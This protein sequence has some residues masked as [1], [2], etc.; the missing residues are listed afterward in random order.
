MSVEPEIL[1]ACAEHVS[2]VAS[3]FDAYRVWCRE[4]SDP[5][6]AYNFIFQRLRNNESVIF[7][8][9]I[10]KRPVGFTQLYPLFSSVSMAP[11]WLLNDLFVVQ[12]VRGKGVGTLLLEAATEFGRQTGAIR[13]ELETEITNTAAQALYEKHGWI[14]NRTQ[15]FYSLTL[16]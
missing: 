3:L 2:S 12:D 14:R 15:Y 5:D 4:P 1:F 9:M 7:L 8:A 11:I 16:E 6:G 13:L 10:D